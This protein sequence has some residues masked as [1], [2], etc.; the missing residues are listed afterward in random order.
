MHWQKWHLPISV[1]GHCQMPGIPDYQSSP[2]TT[3]KAWRR[4]WYREGLGVWRFLHA[5]FWTKTCAWN[6]LEPLFH[7]VCVRN[8]RMP[9]DLSEIKMINQQLAEFKDSENE[10]EK[11]DAAG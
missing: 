4:Q 2:A 7:F 1:S 9:Y 8:E 5:L 6:L 3:A 10:S 11:D